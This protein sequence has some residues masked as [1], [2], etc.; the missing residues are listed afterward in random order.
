MRKLAEGNKLHLF[1]LRADILAKINYLVA[2]VYKSSSSFGSS[3]DENIDL[4]VSLVEET[5]RI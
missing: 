4:P 2:C 1:P 5:E 3:R